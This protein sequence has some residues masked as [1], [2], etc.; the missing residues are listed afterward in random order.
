MEK[1][2]SQSSKIKLSDEQKI[3]FLRIAEAKTTS[4]K[5][6][7]M[8]KS[9]REK[10]AELYYKTGQFERAADYLDK[11]H[12]A[13]QTTGEKD[14]ILPKLL[15]AYLRASKVELAAGLVGKHLLK[16]DLAPDNAV[17][18]SIDNYLSKP[19][20]GADRNTILK[21]LSQ[22]KLSSPRPKWQQWLKNWTDRLSKGKEVEKANG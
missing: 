22:I 13:V 2:T 3:A 17:L 4:E 8:L 14:K 1:F 12:K 19:P 7:I 6:T 5:R 15:D 11:L 16:E 21:T 9:V 20:A 18:G 10:L